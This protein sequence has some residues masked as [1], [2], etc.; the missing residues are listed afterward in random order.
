MDG[1]E[2]EGKISLKLLLCIG[3]FNSDGKM[4]KDLVSKILESPFV[5]ILSCFPNLEDV[6]RRFLRQ[7]E[8]NYHLTTPFSSTSFLPFSLDFFAPPR[9]QTP[10]FSLY[11]SRS[12]FIF[13]LNF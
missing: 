2:G 9:L 5:F 6:G 11:F 4:M 8:G 13:V 12:V 3:V 7:G 1:N 10:K